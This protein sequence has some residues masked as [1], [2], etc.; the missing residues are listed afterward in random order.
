VTAVRRAIALVLVG[1]STVQFGAAIAASMFDRLGPAGMVLLRLFFAAVLLLV[2]FRPRVRGRPWPEL[3]LAIIFGLVLGL[4]NWSFYEAVDR[5]PLGPTVTI[6]FIG[7]MAVGIWGSR[8]P[9]DLLWVLFAFAGVALLANP[10]GSGA[11]AADGVILAVLAG[12][13]WATYI[14][15]SARIGRAWPGATGLSFAM[16]FGALVALPAGIH[17]GG[18]ELLQPEVLAIGVV[19]ALASSVIPY[20]LEMEALRTLPEGVFGVLMSVE[21]AVAALAGLV[22]LGQ[23]LSVGDMVAIG[24][25][26]IA[27][28]GAAAGVR[29]PVVAPQPG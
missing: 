25:V 1:I 8:R 24:L 11:L 20:S 3:R 6:E 17:Q 18:S 28:A 16:G 5:I 23:G 27:S 19:V 15:L 4:M 10:F 13:C 14:L 29:Q 2:L 22:I 9:L 26:V 21:P 12:C 7:P